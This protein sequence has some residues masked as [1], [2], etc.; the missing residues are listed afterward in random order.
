MA[1]RIRCPT[2]DIARV[3]GS[4]GGVISTFLGGLSDRLLAEKAADTRG[5]HALVVQLHYVPLRKLTVTNPQPAVRVCG[6]LLPRVF[7]KIQK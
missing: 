1:N 2:L 7:I 5:N 6:F 3:T 4:R